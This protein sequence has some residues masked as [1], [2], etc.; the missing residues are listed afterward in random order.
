MNVRL[1]L[2]LGALVASSL[3]VSGVAEAQRV[4]FSGGVRWS[5][6][7]SVTSGSWHFA[8]P[9]WSPS[10]WHVRGS[11]YVGPTYRYYPR[12]YYVYYPAYVP[13]YY[14]ST[15]YYPVQPA[16]VQAPGV[17]A[18]TPVREPLPRLGIG[19]F[20]G[21]SAVESQTGDSTHESDDLG[22]LGRFRLTP[23]LIIEG[24]IG[25]MTYDVDGVENARVDR[26][27]GASLLYEIGAYNRWAPYILVGTGVQQA[28]VGGE[29]TTTQDY[30]EIGAGLRWAVTPRFHLALEFR[31]GSRGTVASDEPMLTP[32]GTTGRVIT[33]PSASS[34]ETEEDTRG[35]LNAIL[36]F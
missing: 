7:V 3:G 25:K 15:S 10:R 33:P 30:G 5:G 18:V 14:E 27:L 6:G 2:V 26:R 12:P 1:P 35:R 17:V 22:L 19:L 4:R 31:A 20:A 36:Y 11:I 9:A 21:G 23:G 13:S 24:E 34:D 16:A 29:F 28:E 8:R 32:A